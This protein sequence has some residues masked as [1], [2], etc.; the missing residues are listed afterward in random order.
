VTTYRIY[1]ISY[2]GSAAPRKELHNSTDDKAA[3]RA[4]LSLYR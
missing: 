2:D 3:L 4:A 1:T